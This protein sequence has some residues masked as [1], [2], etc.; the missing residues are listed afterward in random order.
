MADRELLLEIGGFNGT[1]TTYYYVMGELSFHFLK[2]GK[3]IFN[4]GSC[5]L[6]YD[7][8]RLFE[9]RPENMA[10][11]GRRFS[12]INGFD[13]YYSNRCRSDLLRYMNYRRAGI[14]VLDIGCA[15]GTTLLAIRNVNAQAALYGL[16]LCEPA[17]AVAGNF[18]DVYNKSFEDFDGEDFYSSFDYIMMGD[19]LEHLLHTDAALQKVLSW[20]RPGGMLVLSVPNVAHISIL[21]GVLEGDWTYVEAGILDRTHV[22]FFTIKSIRECLIRNGFVIKSIEGSVVEL[23]ATLKSL[24]AELTGMKSVAVSKNDLETYQVLCL[25]EKP[26]L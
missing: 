26:V 17:A 3:R 6:Q 12:K 23:D 10:V 21:H 16:E 9:Y 15:C 5:Q 25:A 22:K 24:E 18:A 1:Y 4:V 7:V 14:R 19:V 20:L 8:L 13:W 11:D 2:A